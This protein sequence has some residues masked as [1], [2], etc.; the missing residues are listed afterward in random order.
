MT[1]ER[2]PFAATPASQKRDPVA[3][4]TLVE[5]LARK[6]PEAAAILDGNHPALTYGGL[7]EQINHVLA[8]L[9]CRHVRKQSRV[10]VVVPRGAVAASA[11]VSVAAA[12]V[13]VPLNPDLADDDWPRYFEEFAVDALLTL[14]GTNHAAEAA[15]IFLGL[16]TITLEPMPGIAAGAFS[17]GNT[18]NR[19]AGD[20]EV[21]GLFDDAFVLATSGTKSRPK[22]VPLTH[23]NISHS[24][25]NVIDALQLTASDR[26]LGVLPLFHPHGL[27]SGL[28]STL[29]SGSSVVCLCQFSATEFLS[30][31]C[32]FE[33]TWYTAVPAVHNAIAVEAIRQP[34]SLE[35]H[36][37]RLIRSASAPL[38][39][40]LLADL[41]RLFHVPVV[42][43]YGMTEAASQ[44]ASNPLPPG[45]RKQGSVGIAAGPEV[46]VLDE[47]AR[48]LKPGESGE[49]ALKGPNIARGY[50]ERKLNAASFVNGWFRTGDLGYIDEDGYLFIQG[51]ISD[52]INR[53]GEKIVPGKVEDVLLSHPDVAEAVVFANPHP[54]LGED[55]AA[56]VVVNPQ[57]DLDA[58]ALRSFAF[59]SGRLRAAEV[60]R[61]FAFVEDIPRNPLGKIQRQKLGLLVLDADFS[62]NKKAKKK[63]RSNSDVEHRLAI[64]WAD[65]FQ[66]DHVGTDDN[67]FTLGGDSLLAVRIALQIESEFGVDIEMRHFFETPGLKDLAS[68]IATGSRAQSR[69]FELEVAPNSY[70]NNRVSISQASFLETQSRLAGIPLFNLVFPFLL[71][72]RFEASVF[73]RALKSL[74][75]RHRILR[76]GFRK[77]GNEWLG[78]HSDAINRAI[79]V[80]DWSVFGGTQKINI[81]KSIA[82]DEVWAELDLKKGPAFRVR[83]LRFGVDKHVL[84]LTFH[85]AIMDAWTIK[86]LVEELFT[87]Y[88]DKLEDQNRSLPEPE[89]QYADFIHW[90]RKWCDGPEADRQFEYWRRKLRGAV[91]VFGSEPGAARRPG[92]AT[93]R[94]P[95]SLP[96]DLMHRLMEMARHEHTTVFVVMLTAFKWLLRQHFGTRDLCVATPMANR[97]RPRTDSILGPFENTVIVRTRLSGNLS[98]REAISRVGDAILD[99]HDHQELPYQILIR[100]LESS[101]FDTS[102]AGQ[103]YF[104]IVS[105]FDPKVYL[106]E[107][108]VRR[109]EN[110]QDREQLVLPFS[111]AQILLMLKET[112]SGLVGSCLYQENCFKPGEVE[113][114]VTN[115]CKIL[116]EVAENL[117]AKR[118]R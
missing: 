69:P 89:F 10:A 109:I 51:R 102:M 74:I 107:L 96:S 86:V 67:F 37:L 100:R 78:I 9:R 115:Y 63:H 27:I 17:L 34:G 20:R 62:L 59:N 22:T 82:A 1:T 13:C 70:T 11:I 58:N 98:F 113:D 99:A 5:A 110:F 49:F 19:A 111:T 43:T 16:Q 14:P 33:P 77:L 91:S 71:E 15:A 32:Q 24:A 40:K 12:T 42:E 103:V 75:A 105:Q 85:H 94:V 65:A 106:P 80:E 38:P 68:L 29:Y 83:L 118:N 114:L 4:F 92:F 31:L 116:E 30:Q 66:L 54:R 73:N 45:I 18:G 95:V 55:V 23:S 7:F 87:L 2:S 41:E 101:G 26:L 36:R 93:A 56:A 97:S 44:I 3:I 21:P 48:E 108:S 8:G 50:D 53:G 64:I 57:S 112:D 61:V 35:N 28:M 25:H 6:T 76:T 88:A 60:P 117:L 52:L 72:G 104:S 84:L 47:H 46:A 90:Q 81:A 39:G 79:K